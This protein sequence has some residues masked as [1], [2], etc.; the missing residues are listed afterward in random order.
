MILYEV[1]AGRKPCQR[2][3]DAGLGRQETVTLAGETV[4]EVA[5]GHASL[6]N[7]TQQEWEQPAQTR[8]PVTCFQDFQIDARNLSRSSEVT[9]IST[10][11]AVSSGPVPQSAVCLSPDF[12]LC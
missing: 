11:A 8:P 2:E 4:A 10:A 1:V 7:V 6:I 5:D 3:D 9:K 12:V